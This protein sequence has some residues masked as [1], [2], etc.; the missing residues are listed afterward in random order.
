MYQPTKTTTIVALAG[1]LG[2][3]AAG[4]ATTHTPQT[5]AS[6]PTD[7]CAGLDSAARTE[8][9][10]NGSTVVD[11]SHA[12]ADVGKQLV[13]VPRGADLAIRVEP[14][15]NPAYLERRANCEIAQNTALGEHS[16][17]YSDDNPLAVDDVQVH[18][19]RRG[20][21]YVFELRSNSPSDA[22][23]IQERA[24]ALDDST[25]VV[26]LGSPNRG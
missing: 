19:A 6:A 17:T 25:Q 12:H 9:V 4:C 26:K 16:P 1:V 2:L 14:D 10:L 5:S 13:R 3:F 21:T 8:S 22:R 20:A 11:V 18:V 23:S 24:A 15:T 7:A